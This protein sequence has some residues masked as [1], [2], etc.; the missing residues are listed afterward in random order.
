MIYRAGRVRGVEGLVN[1][2]PG[3][4]GRVHVCIILSYYRNSNMKVDV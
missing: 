1:A 4:D 2:T 3:P